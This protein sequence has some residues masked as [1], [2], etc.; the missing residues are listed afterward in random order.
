MTFYRHQYLFPTPVCQTK[1]NEV[2]INLLAYLVAEMQKTQ[3]HILHVIFATQK[4]EVKCK[5][6]LKEDV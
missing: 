6:V 3:R 4:H 2:D 1:M 5:S